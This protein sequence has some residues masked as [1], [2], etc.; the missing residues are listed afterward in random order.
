MAQ[1]TIL[2]VEFTI[3]KRRVRRLQEIVSQMQRGV[4]IAESSADS[5]LKQGR[6]GTD[7]EAAM[8]GMM[9]TFLTDL[10]DELKNAVDTMPWDYNR[11]FR[12]GVAERDDTNELLTTVIKVDVTV[13]TGTITIVSSLSTTGWF[14]QFDASD[15]VTISEAKDSDHNGVY[16]VSSRTSTTLV[17]GAMSGSNSTNDETMRI[18]INQRA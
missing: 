8:A 10:G 15:T 16:T 11:E 2:A 9:D 14:D 13:S 18:I 17:V 6:Q 5:M 12:C 1:P 7:I 3:L 4:G